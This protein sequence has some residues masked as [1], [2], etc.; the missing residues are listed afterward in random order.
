MKDDNIIYLGGMLGN[1]TMK[2][3]K[4]TLT[5]ERI[6]KLF[7]E[8][9]IVIEEKYAEDFATV[10]TKILETINKCERGD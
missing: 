8:D 9:K 2:I 5:I 6:Q 10:V 1:L 4:T 3:A 7:V